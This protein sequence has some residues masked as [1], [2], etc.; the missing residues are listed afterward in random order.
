MFQNYS[1]LLN[2]W[3]HSLFKLMGTKLMVHM[4]WVGSNMGLQIAIVV[5]QRQQHPIVEQVHDCHHCEHSLPVVG[6]LNTNK[7][8]TFW[9]CSLIFCFYAASMFG[10][11]ANSFP[12]GC[13]CYS[14]CSCPSFETSWCLTYSNYF[15]RLLVTTFDIFWTQH[16]L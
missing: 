4:F 7:L 2:S 14:F 12:I 13:T 10:A 8:V 1:K 9:C 5:V 6:S 15:L 3:I 16:V 11:F